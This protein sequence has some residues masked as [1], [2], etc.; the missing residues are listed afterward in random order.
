MTSEADVTGSDIV[1]VAP[2][3]ATEK[4]AKEGLSRLQCCHLALG[5]QQRLL[6]GVDG[7]PLTSDLGVMTQAS[8]ALHI[9]HFLHTELIPLLVPSPSNL[10]L[11]LHLVLVWGKI[12]GI[13][14][15][16]PKEPFKWISKNVSKS[17]EKLEG[18]SRC[19]GTFGRSWVCEE[20]GGGW[21]NHRK[22]YIA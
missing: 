10:S 13:F 12:G 3:P 5:L 1:H 21:R 11:A 17:F 20:V 16:L 19:N 14:S 8:V 6:Q 9:Q 15:H 7:G 22:I 4:A 18:G 2:H